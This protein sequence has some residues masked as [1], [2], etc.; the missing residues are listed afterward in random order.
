MKQNLLKRARSILV[1]VA[2]L[3]SLTLPSHLLAYDFEVDGIY[4]DITSEN[5]C[6]VTYESFNYETYSAISTYSGSIVIPETVSYNGTDYSVTE[7]KNYAF[8]GCIGMTEV[9]IGNSVTSISYS[10]FSDC[11]GLT[12]VTIGSS[13][14]SIDNDAFWGCT[15]LTKVNIEDLEAWCKIKFKTP[16]CNPLTYA[17]HLYLGD[18]EVSSIKIPES[19]T[20]IGNYAFY[21]CTS[22]TNVDIPESVTEIGRAAFY[23]CSDCA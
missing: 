1:M 17:H 9:I 23:E 18:I 4:Y 13:V 19:V 8:Q 2:T 22:L 15:S 21:E 7:I 16:Y 11:T 12:D 5:T 3:L 14:T 6:A 10:A 20:S